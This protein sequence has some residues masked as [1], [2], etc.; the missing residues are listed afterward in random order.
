MLTRAR[1]FTLP[2]MMVAFLLTVWLGSVVVALLVGTGLVVRHQV[3]RIEVLRTIRHGTLFLARESAG[4]TAW[5][6][7]DL[8]LMAPDR[9]HYRGLRGLAVSCGS[10]SDTLFVRQH[11]RFGVRSFQ[12]GTDSLRLFVVGD[13]TRGTVNRWERL[14]LVS[15]SPATCPDGA[16]ANALETR[17]PYGFVPT[18]DLSPGAPVLA[19]EP[20]ELRLYRSAGRHWLG[21]RSLSGGGSIQPALG[22]LTP[23]G[24]EFVFLDRS[25]APTTDP[26]QVVAVTM[27]LRAQ[28]FEK[29][30]RGWGH[31]GGH[32]VDSQTVSVT[33]RNI[34]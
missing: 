27:T 29:V 15:V 20:T 9:I 28:S 5:P 26:R 22:P 2:E 4:L 30:R 1:G 24:L 10:R 7:A 17:F 19:F 33:F 21:L 12:P 32:L 8:L 16:G 13:S 23:A 25:E 34:P 11:L 14:P 31:A 18:V 3:G 6:D